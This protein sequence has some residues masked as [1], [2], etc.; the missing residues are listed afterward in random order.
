MAKLRNVSVSMVWALFLFCVLVFHISVLLL[1][2]GQFVMT[3]GGIFWS[4]A[5]HEQFTYFV[6]RGVIFEVPDWLS[7]LVYLRLRHHYKKSSVHPAPL[8]QE[9]TEEDQ[10]QNGGGVFPAAAMD[11]G[12]LPQG[13]PSPSGLDNSHEIGKV[14]RILRLHLITTLIRYLLCFAIFI[15]GFAV[16]MV[17]SY[18]LFLISAFW[19]P[20]VVV[21]ANFHQM[22]NMLDTFCLLVC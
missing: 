11:E 5:P 9:S 20:L 10:E 14:M 7:I 15:P 21:K 16:K 6:T 22:D 13:P 18:H 3:P 1:N 4:L 2:N 12:P 19:I 17:V 8:H